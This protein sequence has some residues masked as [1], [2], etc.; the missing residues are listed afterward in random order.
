MFFFPPKPFKYEAVLKMQLSQ[1]NLYPNFIFKHLFQFL[2]DIIFTFNYAHIIFN[3]L[4][5]HFAVSI[6]MMY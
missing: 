1:T 5:F 3:F 2:I 6:M 4:S